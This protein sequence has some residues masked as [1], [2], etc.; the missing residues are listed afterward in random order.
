MKNLKKYIVAIGAFAAMWSACKRDNQINVI[1]STPSAYMANFDLRRLYRGSEVTL[2]KQTMSEAAYIRG[3]VVSDHSGGNMPQGL[4]FV[5]NSKN[6][7]GGIDSLR[8]IAINL[9]DAAANY[10]PG[11][12]VHIKIEGGTLKR[13]NGILQITGLTTASVEKKASGI[14][15]KVTFVTAVNLAVTPERYEGCLTM[16]YSCNF[17]PNIGVETIEGLKTFNDGSG[18]MQVNVSSNANFKS[19]FLPYSANIRGIIIPTETGV[20]QIRPRVKDDFIP[21]S[22]TVDASIPLGPTP[23]IITGFI[24]DVLGGDGNYEYVQ[25]MATQDLDFRQTPFAVVFCRNAGTLTPYLGTAPEEGWATGGNRS[26]K[27]NLTRGTVA[28][29]TFFYVGGYKQINGSG[30]TSI[31]NANW[32]VSKLY[33][34]EDGD[35]GIGLATTG[36]M[37][38][39][40]NPAGIGVFT[41]TNVTPTTAPIDA[42]FFG[43]TASAASTNHVYKAPANGNPAYGYL[44]PNNDHY[45]QA[46]GAT[47]FFRQNPPMVNNNTFAH[48]TPTDNPQGT[49]MKLGGQYSVSTNTWTVKRARTPVSMVAAAALSEIETGAGIFVLLP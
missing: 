27:F 32:I 10:V 25:L 6:M 26:Y 17:E 7:G 38:N 44:I 28:K 20:Q 42:V 11:D 21:T 31:S 46:D 9:G 41:T 12:S 3:Q 8:G 22:L 2:S 47:P 30:S 48:N 24:S 14:T 23:V 34:N 16:I 13:V 15:P 37:P 49:F 4:L 1:K 45:S 35:D 19:E 5:Q 40:G 39:S 29:G 36:L 18:N 33:A 43:S